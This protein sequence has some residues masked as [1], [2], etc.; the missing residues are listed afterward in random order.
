[1]FHLWECC[2]PDCVFKAFFV[3]ESMERKQQHSDFG[4]TRQPDKWN[5]F[6]RVMI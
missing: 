3:L 1:M 5:A 2:G 4:Q 6:L